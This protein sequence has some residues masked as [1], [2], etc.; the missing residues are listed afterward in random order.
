MDPS[1][2]NNKLYDV[3]TK[4]TKLGLNLKENIEDFKMVA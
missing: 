1:D 3:S 4:I 2:Y